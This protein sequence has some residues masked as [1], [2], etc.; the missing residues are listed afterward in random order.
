MD[1]AANE[2]IKTIIYHQIE[3]LQGINEL[4]PTKPPIV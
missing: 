1:L 3:I 2:E 4:K